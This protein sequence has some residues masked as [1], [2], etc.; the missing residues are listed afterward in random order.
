VSDAV[1][2][3][4]GYIETNPEDH[5]SRLLAALLD[6]VGELERAVTRMMALPAD[7]RRTMKRVGRE[8][9]QAVNEGRT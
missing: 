6:R 8:V 2:D 5:A 7:E 1:E 9:L 4:L 3:A